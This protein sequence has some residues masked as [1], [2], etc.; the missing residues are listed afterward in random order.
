MRGATILGLAVS[1]A[2]LLAMTIGHLGDHQ[3]DWR[4]NQISTYAAR[5]PYDHF[6]TAAMLLSAAAA[7]I[8]GFLASRHGVAGAGPWSHLIPI[9]AGAVAA[10]LIMLALYEESAATLA[11]LRRSEFWAVRQ[12]SFHDAGLQV[13]FYGALLLVAVAGLLVLASA[14]AFGER[15]LGALIA[16]SGPGAFLLMTTPWTEAVGMA[17]AYLGL[18][19][20]ASLLCLWVAMVLFLAVA[21]RRSSRPLPERSD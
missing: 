7:T 10:G 15:V 8:V 5:A 12:Q 2:A 11:A 17:G 21:A 19:Q 13:F 16:A 14:Q 1:L 4:L 18:Q 6:V 20:R 9:L 3:L